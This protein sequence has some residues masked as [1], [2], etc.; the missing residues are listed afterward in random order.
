MIVILLILRLAVAVFY[1]LHP[2]MYVI[3]PVYCAVDCESKLCYGR[4]V[5]DKLGVYGLEPTV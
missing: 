3:K 2:E 5:I 1:A 4:T